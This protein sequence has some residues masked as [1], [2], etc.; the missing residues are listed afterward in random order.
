MPQCLTPEFENSKSPAV[1]E[2]LSTS[3]HD[4]L[5]S[6]K[7]LLFHSSRSVSAEDRVFEVS[8]YLDFASSKLDFGEKLD[9]FCGGGVGGA[10]GSSGHHLAS[11]TD[12]LLS[13]TNISG[14][15]LSITCGSGD[16]F[17]KSELDDFVYLEFFVDTIKPE[18]AAL[19]SSNVTFTNCVNNFK[20]ATTSANSIATTTAAA[21]PAVVVSTA[22][23]VNSANNGTVD[24]FYY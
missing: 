11:Q 19:A 20:L 15:P 22:S 2:L 18:Y 21:S 4:C 10:N 24:I 8:D 6:K 12:R 7:S 1:V 14:K 17:G 3:D 23:G 16:F 5:E 13:F 9:Q